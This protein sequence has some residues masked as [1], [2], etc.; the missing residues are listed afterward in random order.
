MIYSGFLLASAGGAAGTLLLLSSRREAGSRDPRR[1]VRAYPMWVGPDLSAWSP[2]HLAIAAAMTAVV[3]CGAG[4]LLQARQE[5]RPSAWF[6]FALY[7]LLGLALNILYTVGVLEWELPGGLARM[8]SERRGGPIRSSPAASASSSSA[9]RDS[10]RATGWR[11]RPPPY[12]SPP[13][14]FWRLPS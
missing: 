5:R 8:I 10:R 12:R 3:L 11:R 2:P 1:W 9:W 7:T 4:L 14:D 6:A 13:F